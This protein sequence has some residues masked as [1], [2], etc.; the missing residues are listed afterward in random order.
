MSRGAA[1]RAVA[2][3]ASV[4]PPRLTRETLATAT[5]H[6]ARRDATLG[7]LVAAHGVPPLWARPAGFRTLTRI[8]LEQQVSLA[9]AAT[10]HRRVAASLASGWTPGCV[11]AAG[12]RGMRARGLTR[13]K[14]RYVV[15]LAD[16]VARGALD[17]RA[18]HSADDA[19]AHA[20]LV[21]VPGIGPW[22]AG[23]YLLMV[24]RRPD[25]WPPGDLALHLALAEATGRRTRPSSADATEWAERW[26]P[27][28]AVAARILW[29]AYLRSRGRDDP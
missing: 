9:S 8:I 28:R 27:W 7:R 14:A 11:L 24:L 6:L 13:Q 17:L 16:H 1:T 5:R 21:A 22:T 25:I 3:D 18:L 23:I 19:A 29:H 26:S 15:A 4:R 12:E 2:T 10:L 20:A